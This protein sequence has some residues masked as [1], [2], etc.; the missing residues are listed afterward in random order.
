MRKTSLVFTIIFAIPFFAL[1]QQA[2]RLTLESRI[3]DLR[4]D[5]AEQ[6]IQVLTDPAQQSFYRSRILF[7][8]MLLTDDPDFQD[9]F[10]AQCKT[11]ID[12]LDKGRD[13]ATSLS[14]LS[15]IYMQRGVNRFVRK[16]YV[17]ALSDLSKAC[18]IANDC[19]DKHPS[20]HLPDKLLGIYH[21]ALSAVPN[22][23]QWLSGWLCFE[24]DADKGLDLLNSNIKSDGILIQESEA[25]LFFYEKNFISDAEK[26]YT[27]IKPMFEDYPESPLIKLFYASACLENGKIDETVAVLDQGLRFRQNPDVFWSPIWDLYLG[28]AKMYSEDYRGAA[29]AFGNFLDTYKGSA[30]KSDAMYRKAICQELSGA[31]GEAVT[32][33]EELLSA[34][35]SGFDADEYASSM[36]KVYSTRSM[37]YYEKEMY[38]ARNLSDGGS[39]EKSNQKLIP[40]V[41]SL[42]A[43]TEDEKTELYYRFGR[44][45]H[46]QGNHSLAKFYY[47]SSATSNADQNLWMKVY[48]NYYLGKIRSENGL[49]EEA[50]EAYEKALKFN[51][52]FYQQGLERMCKSA[53]KS[54]RKLKKNPT[55]QKG[56]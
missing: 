52:Y 39:F 17:G 42:S 49:Y 2:V 13:D 43:M 5:E 38:R 30:Y 33:Y 21:L 53:L 48:A 23:L 8:K 41:D 10:N 54:A 27:R 56:R 37:T 14:M 6:L 24:G 9:P 31:R 19:K 16:K 7:Y 26:A 44:N 34:G 32:T 40:L 55:S 15:E 50:I 4:F 36:A 47:L 11:G 1:S 29:R 18:N 22:K 45:Y 25:I 3:I 20:S 46:K 35:L 28:R 51:D 12:L